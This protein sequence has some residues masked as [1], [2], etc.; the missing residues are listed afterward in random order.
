MQ[1]GISESEFTVT[2]IINVKL[3]WNQ[4]FFEEKKKQCYKTGIQHGYYATNSAYLVF[5]RIMV[6][7]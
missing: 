5:N 1:Q 6:D 4:G 7:S 3:L 2:Y